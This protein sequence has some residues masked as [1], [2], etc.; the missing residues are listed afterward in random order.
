MIY[1]NLLID[2]IVCN[3]CYFNSYLVLIE[4]DKRKLVDVIICG[5]VMDIMFSNILLNTIVMLVTYWLFRWLNVKKRYVI[6]K[7]I[8]IYGMYVLIRYLIHIFI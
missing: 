2:Y 7:N 8:L 1:V 3:I 6:L 4:L 5:L